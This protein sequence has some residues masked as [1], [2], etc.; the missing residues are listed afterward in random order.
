MSHVTSR[1]IAPFAALP[2]LFVCTIPALVGCEGEAED[3]Q[4][5]Q[6]RTPAENAE[7]AQEMNRKALQEAN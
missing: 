3:G 2:L 1:P 7:R 6:T 5:I 4:A